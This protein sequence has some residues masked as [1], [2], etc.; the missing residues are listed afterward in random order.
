MKRDMGSYFL[1]CKHTE[2][3]QAV[4]TNKTKLTGSKFPIPSS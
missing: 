3:H 2:T 4:L 1:T